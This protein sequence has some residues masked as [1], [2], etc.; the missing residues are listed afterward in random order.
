MATTRFFPR[1]APFVSDKLPYPTLALLFSIAVGACSGPQSA[2]DPAGHGAQSIA[3]IFWLMTAA[4]LIIWAVVILLALWA[5]RVAPEAQDRRRA[6]IMIIGGGAV[7]PTLLLSVLLLYGLAPIPA[8]VAPAPSGSLQIEVSGEQWWWRVRYLRADGHAVQLANEIRVPVGAPVQFRLSSPDVIHSFWIPPL[9]GKIDM[10]PGRVTRLALTPT[11]TGTF[12]GVCAEYCG[13]SHA[14]MA[15]SVAV[16]E[17]EEFSRW[18]ERQAQPAQAPSTE[19]A[20]RGR[21]AFLDN[22]C[23]ACHAIRG[24]PAAGLIGPDLTHVGSRLSLGA[25]ILPNTEEALMR[26]LKH[27]DRIKPGVLMPAFGMLP[28]TELEALAAYLIGL[29]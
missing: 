10:I 12:R 17:T 19:L 26:W 2:L 9:G 15:F 22:G 4:A 7:A 24:T 25:G 16:L 29:K 3:Q 8:L 14:L 1:R 28:E 23:G 27:T 20:A 6:N 5:A 13:T 11:R 18:L 21:D